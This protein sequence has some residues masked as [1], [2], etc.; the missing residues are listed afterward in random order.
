MKDNS[1]LKDLPPFSKEDN[2]NP[3]EFTSLECKPIYK[4]GG[5]GATLKRKKCS[6]EEVLYN[7][8][9]Y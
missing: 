8:V 5:M 7:T 3:G 4:R 9:L 1:D 6:S 2:S